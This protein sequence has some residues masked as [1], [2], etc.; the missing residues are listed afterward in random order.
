MKEDE[1][2]Q[3]AERLIAFLLALQTS[4]AEQEHFRRDPLNAMRRFNLS[5]GTMKALEEA[6]RGKGATRLWRILRITPMPYM[7][8]TVQTKG[9]ARRTP[10]RS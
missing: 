6:E 8:H 4:S 3:E 7:T 9:R 2:I 10:K 1:R 5:K